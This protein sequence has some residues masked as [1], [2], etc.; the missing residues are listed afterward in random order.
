MATL[1]LSM[2][3]PPALAQ[4]Q[5]QQQRYRE[6]TIQ[7]QTGE[8]PEMIGELRRL[9]DQAARLRAADP[10]FIGDL[11]RLADIYQERH[12]YAMQWPVQLVSEDFRDGDFTRNPA[13]TPVEGNWQIVSRDNRA[14]LHSAILKPQPAAPPPAAT[15][16]PAPMTGQDVVVG[17]LGAIIRQQSGQGAQTTQPAPTPPAAAVQPTSATIQLPATISNAFALKM[18]LASAG[19]DGRLDLAL[20]RGQPGESAYR[21]IY[22]PAAETGL[23]LARLTP[24][25]TK[26]LGSSTGRVNLE[27]DKL[28]VIEWRRDQAGKM[29]VMLDGKPMIEVSDSEIRGRLDGLTLVNGGGSHWIAS[30]A[31]NGAREP[32]ARPDGAPS[33]RRGTQ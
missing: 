20:Y 2:L 9:T 27:D 29:S 3:A 16:A 15:G 14:M 6:Q 33:Y 28:H 30:L 18:E 23:V 19:A 10:I 7:A 13:W 32:A 12:D 5:Q 22:S 4:Q 24:Q 31:V 11:R 26:L 21:L 8:L 17:V 25:G 1:A